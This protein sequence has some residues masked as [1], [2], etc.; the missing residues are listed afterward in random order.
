MVIP[1]V[2]LT[3]KAKTA[4]AAFIASFTGA[5][6]ASHL[7]LGSNWPKQTWGTMSV[8]WSPCQTLPDGQIDRVGSDAQRR[9]VVVLLHRDVRPLPPLLPGRLPGAR[10]NIFYLAPRG[11]CS[12]QLHNLVYLAPLCLR[13]KAEPLTNILILLGITSTWKSYP[14]LGDHAA[15]TALLACFPEIVPCKPTVYLTCSRYR[16]LIA[17]LRHPLF[18][19]SVHLYTSILLPLL[20]SLWLLTG[21]GNANFF[22]AATMVYGLNASLAVVDVVSAAFKA[23]LKDVVPPGCELVQLTSVE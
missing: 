19:A 18:T 2:S 5:S 10:R 6:L 1:L 12:S 9:H 22:Y 20:H 23:R 16:V 7:L 13:F 15:W 21:A 11:R 14:Q 3:G 17:D 4:L 8:T